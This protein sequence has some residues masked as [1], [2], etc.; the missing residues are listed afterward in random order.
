MLLLLLCSIRTGVY[1]QAIPSFQ[2]LRFDE[3]YAGLNRD[4]TGG[5]Y[6][7]LKYTPLNADSSAWLSVGGEMRCQYFYFRN[8]NWGNTAKDKDGYLFSRALLHADLHAG[9]YFRTFVQLQSSVAIGKNGDRSAVEKNPLDLHQVFCE[10]ILPIGSQQK[11]L[12]RAGRQELLYGSQRLVA[13]R[14]G[15][16]SR[17]AFDAVQVNYMTRNFRADAFVSCYVIP[18]KQIF[19]DV[20]STDIKLW[21]LYSVAN[22]VPILGNID[23][24]Y[25][26]LSRLAANFDDG[27]GTERRHSA[28]CRI[29]KKTGKWQY[30]IEGLYQWGRFGSKSITAWTISSNT[31]YQFGR[32]PFGPVVALKAELISGDRSPGDSH[33]NTFNP[34]FP[35]GG[36]LGLAALVGPSNLVDLHP[37]LTFT[38]SREINLYIDYAAFWRFSSHD[39]IYAPNMVLIYSGRGTSETFIGHQYASELAFN[40]NPFLYFRLEFTWFNTGAYLNAAGPGKDIIVTGIT[41]QLKF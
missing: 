18:G 30:D 27:K 41:G 6:R 36:Y 20:F 19:D 24:Y 12:L 14:D 29:W 25:L 40:P 10:G 26:G 34:M 39:G 3:D 15:P 23:C 35:R 9:K 8:E 16:N 1:G 32:T 7:R 22:K 2:P 5:W 37:S 21:G 28:G 31:F 38:F 13:V 11:L 4:S 33:L 17:Q